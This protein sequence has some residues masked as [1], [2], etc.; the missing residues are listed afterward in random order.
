MKRLG[1]H[2]DLYYAHQDDEA[3]PLADTLGA[4][5]AL[6][7]AGKVR[8]IGASNY[9]AGAARR[10]ARHFRARGAGA[11]RGAAARI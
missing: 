5:D 6:V 11:L 3:T 9:S 2:I 7:K 10:G 4:F 1:T 8:A